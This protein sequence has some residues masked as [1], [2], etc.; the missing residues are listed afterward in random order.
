MDG[1]ERRCGMSQIDQID[2]FATLWLDPAPLK[3]PT[4]WH[5]RP[6]M[7]GHPDVPWLCI[8]PTTDARKVAFFVWMP[9]G[10]VSPVGITHT[11]NVDFVASKLMAL[12]PG[13]DLHDARGLE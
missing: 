10:F 6:R 7:E 1:R 3:L 8:A 11:L 2:T 9:C 4:R 12:M 13:V 5:V